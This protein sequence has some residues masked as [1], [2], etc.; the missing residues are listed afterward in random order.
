MVTR[1]GNNHSDEAWVV[2]DA[3]LCT[4]IARP[5]IAR[6]LKRS[7]DFTTKPPSVKYTLDINGTFIEDIKAMQ[8]FETEAD[9]WKAAISVTRGKIKHLRDLLD[10]QTSA[11]WET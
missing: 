4:Q 8:I 11:L 9:A 3:I 1:D 6:I 7:P 5:A 10:F 2:G